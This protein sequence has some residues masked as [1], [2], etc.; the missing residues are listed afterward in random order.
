[1]K[2]LILSMAVVSLLATACKKNADQMAP[3]GTIAS[4]SSLPY[5]TIPNVVSSDMF[6]DNGHIWLLD[7]KSFV[8]EGVTLII[9][10]GTTI[11]GIRKENTA[12][13]SA[14]VVTRGAQLFAVGTSEFPIVFT[15]HIDAATNPTAEPGDWGGVV[16]LGRAPVNQPTDP[17]IEGINL[18]TVPAGIDVHY[19]GNQPDDKSGELQYVRIEYAGAAISTDNELNGLTGGGI[20]SQT[21]LDNIEVA[22]GAD[23]AFEFFGGVVNAKHLFAYAPNDDAFDFDFGAQVNIQYGVSVLKNDLAYSANPNGFEVDNDASG[24]SLT[25]ITK[26]N[27]SN[28]TVIGLETSAQAASKSLLNAAL[29][30]RNSAFLVKNSLFLGFPT[31]LNHATA[32]ADKTFSYNVVQAFGAVSNPAGFPGTNNLDFAG[33]NANDNI[34]LV[35]PFA[36]TPDFRPATTSSPAY[37]GTDYAGLSA[38]HDNVSYRGAFDSNAANN[39]LAGWARFNY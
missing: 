8:A 33:G 38:F 12:E 13:A 22:Y 28:F 25:P 4:N 15:A 16:L 21:V 20:G 24:S 14:L 27:V 37:A 7:G 26:V 2:R 9:Q 3:R 29:Y 39:W 19:G 30:R 34:G 10:E 17:T 36:A 6:L 18:P 32:N 35:A 11:E 1:M 5:E 31:G 23:D